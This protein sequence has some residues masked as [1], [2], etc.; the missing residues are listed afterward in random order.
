MFLDYGD[1]IEQISELFQVDNEHAFYIF[2]EIQD[3]GLFNKCETYEQCKAVVLDYHKSKAPLKSTM[4]TDVNVT[5]D[6]VNIDK[7][8]IKSKSSSKE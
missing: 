8:K 3:A 2:E 4:R 6:K 7:A 5:G 1:Y